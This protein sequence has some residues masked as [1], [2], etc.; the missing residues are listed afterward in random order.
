MWNRHSEYRDWKRAGAF[1]ENAGIEIDLRPRGSLSV[2]WFKPVDLLVEGNE[3][4]VWLGVRDGI[5]NWLITG[6]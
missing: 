6:A 2:A 1:P 5:R 4:E 3:A